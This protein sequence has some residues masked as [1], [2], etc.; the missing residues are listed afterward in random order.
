MV[1]KTPEKKSFN[2]GFPS[3]NQTVLDQTQNR[4]QCQTNIGRPV[5]KLSDIVSSSL[6]TPASNQKTQ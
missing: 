5:L 2:S 3:S 1:A 4:N 6:R